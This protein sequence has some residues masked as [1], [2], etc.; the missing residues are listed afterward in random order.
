MKV[1]DSR[2]LLRVKEAQKQKI[3]EI[4]FNVGVGE[5]EQATV[6]ATGPDI[7]EE[8]LKP[9]DEVYIYSNAG[10]TIKHENEEFRVVTTSEIIVIL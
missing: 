7:K 10:K 9:G 8:N 2:V 5:W 4:E 3:G 1:L 6:I